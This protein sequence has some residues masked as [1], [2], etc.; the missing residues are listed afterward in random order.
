MIEGVYNKQL[1]VPVSPCRFVISQFGT[2]NQNNS[3]LIV[4]FM[5]F[6][7][8]V[9]ESQNYLLMHWQAK[10]K[11]GRRWG[12]FAKQMDGM[13]SYRSFLEVNCSGKPFETLQLEDSLSSVPSAVLYFPGCQ[14][15]VN[16]ETATIIE[17]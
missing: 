4:N 10:P 16:G 5:P 1:I 11:F 17:S 14:L 3:G 12:V 2:G 15:H 8:H 13:E 9:G 7:P 6:I